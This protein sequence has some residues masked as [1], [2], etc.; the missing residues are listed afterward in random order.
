MTERPWGIADL[1]PPTLPKG[2]VVRPGEKIINER[3]KEYPRELDYFNV[4]DAPALKEIYGDKPR[5]IRGVFASDEIRE[6]VDLAYKKWHQ[7]NTLACRGDGRVATDLDKGEDRECLGEECEMVK[8]GKCSRQIYIAFLP[9]EAPTVAIHTFNSGSWRTINNTL[10]FA[11]LL[12]TMYGRLAGIPWVMLREPFKCER[13]TADGKKVNQVHYTIRFDLEKPLQEIR[14]MSVPS[15]ERP[16]AFDETDPSMYPRSIQSPVAALPAGEV[17]EAPVAPG[18]TGVQMMVEAPANPVA[19][20]P[21]IDPTADLLATIS[22]EYLRHDI[23][24]GFEITGRTEEQQMEL[25]E[26]YKGQPERLQAYLSALVDSGLNQPQKKQK[27]QPKVD[28]LP[29]ETKAA[30]PNA[31]PDAVPDR[32]WF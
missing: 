16:A 31:V 32:S 6:V 22:D 18:P 14:P 7:N 8:A 17:V 27:R 9:I 25:L 19:P 10:A 3:G 30:A 11:N 15:F 23:Q 12:Q 4:E 24:L 2:P 13:E 26:R 5:L 28:Q 1:R 21:E 20:A 29:T